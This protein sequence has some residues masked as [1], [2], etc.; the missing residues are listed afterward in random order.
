MDNTVKVKINTLILIG[1]IIILILLLLIARIYYNS[2]LYSSNGVV[3]TFF[4]LFTSIY[5]FSLKRETPTN[6]KMEKSTY[7]PSTFFII[8]YLIVYFQMSIDY[9]ISQEHRNYFLQF[10]IQHNY[11]NK[12]V[13]FSTICLVCIFIGYLSKF[14]LNKEKCKAPIK[15]INPYVLLI[16]M[17]ILLLVFVFSID[18]NYFR[19]Q[20]NEY[21]N[22]EGIPT[23]TYLA[24]QYFMYVSLIYI[25]QTGSLENKKNKKNILG[26]ITKFNFIFYIIISIWSFLVFM[27]GDRG[28][29]LQ[30]GLAYVS[31]YIFS[32]NIFISKYKLIL[33]IFIAAIFISFLGLLRNSDPDMSF[34]ER[35][36]NVQERASSGSFYFS[37][38]PYTAELSRSVRTFSVALYMNTQGFCTYG[39]ILLFNIVT[40]IPGIGIILS[41]IG[42][43]SPEYLNNATSF[44]NSDHSLGISFLDCM[45]YDFGIY[46]TPFFVI[47][48]G[49]FLRYVDSLTLTWNQSSMFTKC[50]LI[51]FMWKAIYLS[52]TDYFIIFKD[53]VVLYLVYTI[54]LVIAKKKE[55]IGHENIMYH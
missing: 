26:Y 28:P 3:M 21:M 39:L 8:G 19:G 54:L 2:L 32:N 6:N 12:I 14:H 37:F 41:Y 5:L 30:I 24:Q 48:W 49:R 55:E 10:F 33:L 18:F 1:Q 52:R 15:I 27:S 20:Y 45:I 31:C 17:S 40:I 42:I 23:A 35:L 4:L 46:L 43:S 51:A 29:V 22:V 38:S 50:L 34:T 13:I 7:R 36:F 25:I 47:L 16:I 53:A 9:V 44:F 11:L